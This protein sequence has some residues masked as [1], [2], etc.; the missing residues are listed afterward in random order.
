MEEVEILC[1]QIVIMDQGQVIAKGTKE[2][3][4]D[5]VRS[6]ENLVI[7][8]PLLPDTAIEFIKSLPQVLETAY[9]KERLTIT[10]KR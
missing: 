8:I 5:M 9:D 1:D 4:K 7:D 2:E 10:A 6:T 3:L